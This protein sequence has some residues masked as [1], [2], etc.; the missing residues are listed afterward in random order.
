MPSIKTVRGAKKVTNAKVTKCRTDNF[1]SISSL[2]ADAL[3]NDVQD[4]ADEGHEGGRQ[5]GEV[6]EG[7]RACEIERAGERARET[8]RVSD[9]L[10]MSAVGVYSA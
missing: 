3:L 2:F 4:R 5:A 10:V 7:E 8:R 9:S 6:S 1:Q